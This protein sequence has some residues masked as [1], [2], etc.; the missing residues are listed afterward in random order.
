MAKQNVTLSKFLTLKENAR[1][2]K[3]K[4]MMDQATEV[5]R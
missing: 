4:V 1:D 5:L 2:M 3:A